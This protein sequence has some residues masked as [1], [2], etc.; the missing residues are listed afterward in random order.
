MDYNYLADLLFPNVKMTE[1]EIEARYPERNLPDGAKVT[2]FAP[3]PTGFV[4]FGGL[5]PAMVGERLAHQSGGV[6]YLRIEDTDSTREVK[7]AADGLIKTL[8]HYGVEFDEGETI[9]GEIGNYGPY[10]QSKR[11]DI[12]QVFAKR[13]V[14]EGRAYPVFSTDKELNEI[15]TVDKKA[16]IRNINWEIEGAARRQA[17]LDR[18][19][20]TIEQVESALAKGQKFALFAI[21]DGDSTKKFKFT[22]LVRGNLELS[23]NDEDVVLLKS[24]GVPTYH[25]AHVVD[26]HLMHT[27][28][29]IRGE[30]WLPSL[31]KHLQL[32]RYMGW[33]APKYMHISQLMKLDA[34]GSKKK[35]SKRDMGANMD[36]YRRLGY[37][38][39]CV[40]EYVMTLLNSNFEEWHAKNKDKSYKDFPFSIKKMSVS[41]CLFDMNKLNDVSK[42]VIS[43][44]NADYIYNALH[45][46]AIDFD[47]DFAKHLSDNPDFAKAIINIGRGGNKPR[48]DYSTWVELRDYMA[49]FYD[50]YFGI[51]DKYPDEIAIGDIKAILSR[52]VD[53]YDV[54]D[55]SVVW[56]DKIKSIASDFGYCADMKLYRKEPQN[57]KGSV[58]DVSMIIRIAITGKKNA[59]D[60][61]TVM[62]ILGAAKCKQRMRNMI[63]NIMT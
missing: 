10:R 24:D 61:Y 29:V 63:K 17:M 26:D 53:E 19:C 36:D 43:T 18:R 35:L 45:N 39:I 15:K 48:K 6:F 52:F 28:H 5:F 62:H 27:T 37:D 12:Y 49:F 1:E 34:D 14:R 41:G 46:W 3:S 55:D 33:K 13:L 58:A 40:S 31:P 11:V 50:A 38:P 60:L 56:F 42:N 16:E 9:D 54:E 20:F 8:S 57:Y 2:R 30:E 4:H 44:M 32:F 22:D 59:P 23:E 51:V 47:K 7:G 21:A 25:F